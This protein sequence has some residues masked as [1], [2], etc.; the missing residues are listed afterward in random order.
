MGGSLQDRRRFVMAAYAEI[1]RQVGADKR[2]GSRA[3]LT[4]AIPAPV[5]AVFW[6]SQEPHEKHVG[7]LPHQASSV[8]S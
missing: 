5:S 7:H 4:G 1:R 2:D 6:P 8:V 3:S